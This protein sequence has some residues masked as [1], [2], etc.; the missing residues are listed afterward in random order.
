MPGIHSI[1]HK[2]F[3][4]LE[5]LVVIALTAI[6][7]GL[8]LPAVQKVRESANRVSCFNNLKQIGLALHGFMDANG[9][10]PPNGL[11]TY[12]STTNTVVQTSPWS[13]LSRILPFVEQEG[14]FHDIDFTTNYSTQPGITSKRITTYLCPDEQNDKGS[15]SD[16]TF[17]NKNWTLSYAA[18]LGT[19][20]VLT[21]KAASMKGTDGAFSPDR[22]FNAKDFRDGLSNTIAFSEVKG[23]TTRVTGTPNTATFSAAPPPPT[24]VADLLAT[25]PFGLTGITLAAFDP[26]KLTHVEWVD[27]KVH[28]TGFTT[29]F[30]P[31][32]LVPFVNDGVTYDVDFVSATEANPGDTYAAVTAR[33]YHPSLVNVVL[34]DGSV[35]SVVD[36]VNLN[37]WRALGTRAGGEAVGGNDF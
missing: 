27:G 18:N 11:F 20:A 17:G 10:L 1:R 36:S 21:D 5:L 8:L 32:T 6:L 37:V 12:D 19:W 28:E 24:S 25:P 4:L 16:P 2:A 23:Y 9:E 34:M 29:A 33:S 22:G 3:T 15:G 13:A 35:R 31:N 14:L 30:K 26:T 7:I